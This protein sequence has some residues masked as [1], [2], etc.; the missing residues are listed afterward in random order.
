MIVLVLLTMSVPHC[1]AAEEAQCALEY[2]GP[3][4]V[5]LDHE[6]RPGVW[7]AG[8]VLRCMVEQ[9]QEHPLLLQRV[10]LLE[11]QLQLRDD[12]VDRLR[13]VVSL[14]EEGEHRATEAIDSAIARAVAAED[15][16]GVWYRSPALWFAVGAVVTVAV[17][18]LAA[19]AWAQVSD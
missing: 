16:A 6:G 14:A 1:V 5:T 4:R 11:E 9:L 7:I 17:V 2:D 15:R 3:R 12:Q 10:S 19:W 8:P 13:E 18:V